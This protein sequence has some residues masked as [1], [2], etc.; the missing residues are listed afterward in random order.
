MLSESTIQPLNAK[1]TQPLTFRTITNHHFFGIFYI[2]LL[3]E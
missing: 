2:N 1:K 3:S